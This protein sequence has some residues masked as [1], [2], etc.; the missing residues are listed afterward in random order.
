M[1]KDL[2]PMFALLC[3]FPLM[4]TAA[5]ARD[6]SDGAW[7]QEIVLPEGTVVV[8][9]P[10]PEKLE[11]D[12]LSARTAFAVE[13]EDSKDPVFGA[14]WAEARLETDRS[15]RTAT[16]ADVKVSG[17][18]LP[19]ED[20]EKE[21][22]IKDLIE[23]EAPNWD[24]VIDMDRLLA[25]LEFAE[26]RLRASEKLEN[27]PPKIY[28]FRE[29]AVLVTIDGE[30]R[31]KPE[32]GSSLMRVINTPFTILFDTSTKTYYLAADADSWYSAKEL[33]GDWALAR[34]VPE[35]VA[36]RAPGADPE[37]G[38]PEG[39]E[40]GEAGPPPKIVVSTEP[41][42]LIA[43]K[44]D[45]EYTPIE[46]TDLLYVGNTDSDLLMDIGS[47]DHYLLLS[48]R[49]YASKKLEGPWKYV[50]GEKLPEDFAK[51]PED[52]E[53]GTV[54]YAVPG[55]DVAK[56]AVLDAQL[57][58]TAAVERK[59]AS[60]M[61]EYDGEPKFEKIKGTKMTYAVNTATP[62]IEVKGTFYACD[63]G[64][65]FVAGTPTGPWQA[66]TEI[67]GEVYTIPPDSPVYHVTF[68]KVYKA[69]DD[70][71]YVG[72]TPGYTHTYV[73]H[74][75]IVYGTGW[76]RPGWHGR[77]YY[78][79]PST[80]GYHARW[81]PWGGWG[82]GFSY[83]SGPFTFSLGYGG[84]W[85]RGGWWGPTHYHTYYR[86]Y[87]HGYRRG[88]YAGYRAGYRMGRSY[89]ER[90]NLY[91]SGRNQARTLSTEQRAE[92]R[93]RRGAAGAAAVVA[94]G[95]AIAIA[96]SGSSSRDNNVY[97]DRNGNV[98]RRT[99]QGWQ[100]RRGNEWQSAG[101]RAQAA[102]RAE[103]VRRSPQGQRASQAYSSGAG[104]RASSLQQLDRSSA[105]R[106]RGAQR[107]NSF[108]QSRGGY[109]RPSGG[110]R[111]GGGGRGR[112]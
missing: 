108:S 34:Q 111:R 38:Q 77:W 98:Y 45:P 62:V 78:P 37:A 30:P 83:S 46:G 27:A 76:W 100:Q 18:R 26:T 55:T 69:T 101:Q 81:N 90:Q 112:R 54:L 88:S 95:A 50:P 105:A 107:A 59:K 20:R 21:N 9:Q 51:I 57:P 97:T 22:K 8:Y 86:N 49:W 1:K 10:Q 4:S 41:A 73:Y 80:W 3:T 29:P 5:P 110:G 15:D 64:V 79:R 61:V 35:D 19:E 28:F 33:A 56:E 44:G 93:S 12:I 66:A 106:Q 32:E 36:A 84:S 94:G 96:N 104:S 13:L 58:Q 11:G 92:V 31:L 23:R 65:W 48:G 75:T 52:S 7:P 91:A 85:Y 43:M 89:E 47:Q 14:L 71:V 6:V 87:S 39:R 24:L 42:E 2:L 109:S 60:L 68:V 74:D 63:E 82:F 25:T 70:V 16:L 53:M 17:V 103:Q 102:Q 40:K 67:P 99:D 72:Y